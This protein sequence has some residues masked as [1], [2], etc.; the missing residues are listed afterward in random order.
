MAA[1]VSQLSMDSFSLR[2]RT[3][4]PTMKRERERN[5]INQDGLEQRV[6]NGIML[7]NSFSASCPS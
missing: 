2:A 1:L 6:S 4:E 3:A 5:K 7:Q